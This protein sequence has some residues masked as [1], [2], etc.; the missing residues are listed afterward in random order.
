MRRLDVKK[1]TKVVAMYGSHNGENGTIVMARD[2]NS[3]SHAARVRF[4]K[5]KNTILVPIGYLQAK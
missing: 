1:G 5:S 4:G 3:Q 2:Y